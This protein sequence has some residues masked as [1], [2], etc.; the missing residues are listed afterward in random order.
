ML[1]RLA[2]SVQASY[3]RDIARIKKKKKH[4]I[5]SSQVPFLELTISEESSEIELAPLL[6]LSSRPKMK[7]RTVLDPCFWDE[8]SV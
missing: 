3:K 1:N 7:E 8:D 4:Y 5:Q 2:D 6:L